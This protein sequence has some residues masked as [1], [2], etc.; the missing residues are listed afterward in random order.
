MSVF[1]DNLLL[2]VQGIRLGPGPLLHRRAEAVRGPRHR[3]GPRLRRVRPRAE[4]RPQDAA[5]LLVSSRSHR[6]RSIH[7]IQASFGLTLDLLG[8]MKKVPL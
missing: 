2:S 5:D 7:Q 3:E 8:T 1:C 6:Q 4:Q